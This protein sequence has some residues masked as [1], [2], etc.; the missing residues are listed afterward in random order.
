M[1]DLIR[2]KQLE[3]IFQSE[4]EC[5]CFFVIMMHFTFCD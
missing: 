3:R 5:L 1:V 2:S 4:K